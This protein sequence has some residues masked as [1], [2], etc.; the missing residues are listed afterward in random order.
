MDVINYLEI[1]GMTCHCDWDNVTRINNNNYST[2]RGFDGVFGLFDFCCC[3][4]GFCCFG[5]KSFVV[6][7][8][9]LARGVLKFRDIVNIV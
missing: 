4:F 2:G 7:C 6:L 5:D 1:S 8:T 9:Y 3:C